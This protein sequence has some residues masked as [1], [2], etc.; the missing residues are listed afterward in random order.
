MLR[1]TITRQFSQNPL[2][3]IR[4][5]AEV[6]AAMNPLSVSL[7]AFALA[8]L[9]IV[10]SNSAN[11][12]RAN[13]DNF[14]PDRGVYGGSMSEF[15]HENYRNGGRLLARRECRTKC[16]A[17]HYFYYQRGI[18]CERILADGAVPKRNSAS[19]TKQS[20]MDH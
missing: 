1:L 18:S 10:E 8:R 7:F 11:T 4:A 19:A 20:S 13:R 12:A 9:K 2:T 3:S 6:S 5:D 17:I 16:R 14:I 15:T